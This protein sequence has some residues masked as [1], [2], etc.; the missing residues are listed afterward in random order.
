MSF[1]KSTWLVIFM[2]IRLLMCFNIRYYNQKRRRRKFL[3]IWM[4]KLDF[5][6]SSNTEI[7]YQNQ[8]ISIFQDTSNTQIPLKKW[9][10]PYF[11]KIFACGA[12]F[13]KSALT[14]PHPQG[15]YQGLYMIL[16]LANVSRNFT[17]ISPMLWAPSL[18][19]TPR[20]PVVR[21]LGPDQWRSILTNR[22]NLFP[23]DRTLPEGR[24]GCQISEWGIE[25]HIRNCPSGNL[26]QLCSNSLSTPRQRGRATTLCNIKPGF[27]KTCRAR[28]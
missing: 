3:P 4:F 15:G 6:H 20:H 25:C 19:A 21:L 9:K 17:E 14:P 22:T 1:L 23:H 10:N 11:R 8:L 27:G 2:E 28:G 7:S 24:N 16:T 13:R 18:T 12:Y 26:W 5:K